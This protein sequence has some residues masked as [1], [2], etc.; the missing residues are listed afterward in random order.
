MTY[1]DLVLWLTYLLTV[2]AIVVT[3]WSAVHGWKT[4]ER[5]SAALEVRHADKTGYL[6]TA[7][8]V[9]TLVLTFLFGSSEPLPSNGKLYEDTF[10]L[11]ATDMFIFTSIILITICSAVIVAMRF[12]R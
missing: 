9:I 4:R 2:A 11:K 8:L 7:L 6:T 10:W 12:R 3:V 5:R 1:V